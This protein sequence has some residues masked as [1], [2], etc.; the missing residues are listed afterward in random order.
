MKERVKYCD[1]LRFISI[2]LVISIHILCDFRD[3]YVGTDTL[4]YAILSFFD[5]LNRAAVPIFLM[6]T[7]AFMLSSNK[8]EKYSEFFI[9]R[10]TKLFFPFVIISFIY[11]LFY[12]LNNNKDF[13]FLS[14]LELFTSN[15]IKYHFWFMYCIILIYLFIPF[16]KVMIQNLKKKDILNLSILIFVFGNIL[17]FIITI[18][19]RFELSFMNSF[20]LSQNIIC[21]NYLFVGYYL[22]NND[23]SKRNKKIIY[24]LAIISIVFLNIADHF[25][26]TNFRDDVFFTPIS[27]FSIMPGCALFLIFKDYYDKLKIPSK[28]NRFIVDNSKYIFYVYM[29]HVLVKEEFVIKILEKFLLPSELS[30]NFIGVLVICVFRM[31]F[32]L[33][34]SFIVAIVFEYLYMKLSNMLSIIIN[35]YQ[36][37]QV[38]T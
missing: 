5:S 36:K 24:I 11:Y 14:F 18:S 21:V 15:K 34:I 23:I 38:K 10:I 22:Y 1:A 2:F 12:I 31:F 27:I 28:I 37:K 35:K 6:I 25:Y 19:S 32:T 7:G 8:K 4:K 13:N 29:L 26:N 17:S 33:I 9:K 30:N 20:A 16:L 3:I